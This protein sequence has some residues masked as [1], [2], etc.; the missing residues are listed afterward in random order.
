M[1]YTRISDN[2][3]DSSLWADGTYEGICAL[4][5]FLAILGEAR[6]QGGRFRR[7]TAPKIAR[8]AAIPFEKAE[9]AIQ[10]LTS[11]DDDDSSGIADGRRLLPD[12]DGGPNDYIV[13]NWERYGREFARA[14]KAAR[15]RRWREKKAEDEVGNDV[16]GSVYGAS[17]GRQP[18]DGQ[19]TQEEKKRGKNL[20]TGKSGLP[21]E[22]C[23][24]FEEDLHLIRTVAKT[25]RSARCREYYSKQAA[26]DGLEIVRERVARG[27][28]NYGSALAADRARGFNRVAKEDAT[29]LRDCLA[30]DWQET[31]EEPIPQ[32]LDPGWG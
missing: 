5:A 17:H 20:S 1:S 15:M 32:K 18:G 24:A 10:I 7:L 4:K 31:P 2:L 21:V 6:S 22:V 27:V 28:A 29:L 13:T 9:S 12:P 19:E 30:G 11:P 23:Q 25:A 3:F 14:A 8:I 16:D 26:K